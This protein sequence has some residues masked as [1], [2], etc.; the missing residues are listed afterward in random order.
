MI[1]GNKRSVLLSDSLLLFKRCKRLWND[2]LQVLV[3]HKRQ[4]AQATADYNASKAAY[5]ADA[6]KRAPEACR[7]YRA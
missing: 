3:P 1:P 4:E 7:Q 6:Q 5:D 2:V